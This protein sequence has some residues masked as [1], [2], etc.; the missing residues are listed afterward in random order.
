MYIFSSVK[1]VVVTEPPKKSTDS[2]TVCPPNLAAAKIV[3]LSF[4]V[5]VAVK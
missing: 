2:K 5:F 4:R 1:Y 3:S